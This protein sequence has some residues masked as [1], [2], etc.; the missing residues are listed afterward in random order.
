MASETGAQAD[1]AVQRAVEEILQT[2][3]YGQLDPELVRGVVVRESA[4]GRKGKA[5][6][7]AAKTKLHQMTGAYRAES[8]DY[9]AWLQAYAAAPLDS[10]ERAELCRKAMQAHASTR[11]RLPFLAEFYATLLADVVA[12]LRPAPRIVDLAC[13]LNPLALAWMPLPGGYQYWACDI[14]QPQI[15]F[16]NGYF[17]AG[18]WPAQAVRH[19]LI[20]GD[21]AAVPPAD[22]V[23]L[24]KTIPCLEQLES[25]IGARLLAELSCA[26]AFVS[27]PTRSLGGRRRGMEDHYSAQFERIVPPR[28]RVETFEFPNEIVF[29]LK[30]EG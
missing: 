6:V 1:P 9:A 16:L 22:V 26:V 5:L 17:E 20:H 23:F 2:A 24:F 12:D 13:G 11:E 27:F 4:K 21:P 3:K 18:G 29:K 14:D 15:D 10:S 30:D 8:L 19:D 28:Y 25:G 7:K